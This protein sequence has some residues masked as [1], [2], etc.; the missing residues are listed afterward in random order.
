MPVV[1]WQPIL[2]CSFKSLT[3]CLHIPAHTLEECSSKSSLCV[4]GDTGSQLTVCSV[5]VCG[6]TGCEWVPGRPCSIGLSSPFWLPLFR[7]VDVEYPA[8]TTLAQ[9]AAGHSHPRVGNHASTAHR[10]YAAEE[11]GHTWYYSKVKA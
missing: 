5:V 9:P 3:V 1:L 10:L 8:E 6:F 11:P 4:R 2:F 7:S